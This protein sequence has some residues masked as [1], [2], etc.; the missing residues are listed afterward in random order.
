MALG[1]DLKAFLEK[2]RFSIE[3]LDALLLFH[4][5]RQTEFDS[6]DVA[7]ELRSDPISVTQVLMHL[8][9]RKLI[10][11]RFMGTLIGKY[12]YLGFSKEEERI[13]GKLSS[14]MIT[15]R[16]NVTGFLKNL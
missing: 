14:C 12:T 5:N 6:V 8:Q 10:K 15:E 2:H 3:E 9:A 13:L 16:D 4:A 11:P 1:L 7:R